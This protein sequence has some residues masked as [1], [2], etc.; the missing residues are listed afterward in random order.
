MGLKLGNTAIGSLYLGST[1][2]SEAYMGSSLIYRA[3]T[4]VVSYPYMIF[5]FASSSA[6]LQ[7]GVYIS[8]RNVSVTQISTSPNRWK[9]EVYHW[10]EID[11]QPQLGRGIPLLFCANGSS[12]TGT[13]TSECTLVEAG[14]FDAMLDGYYCESMDRAFTGCTGLTSLGDVIEVPNVQNVAGMFQNC[15]NVASGQL[16]QY[17][18]FNTY[19][20]SVSNHSGTFSNCGSGTQ[21]GTDELDQIPVGWGGNMIPTSTL[22]TSTVGP[23][24]SSNKTSWVITGNAPDWT[25]I[26]GLYLF[27]QSS[28][29][30]FA[31][32]SMNRSRIATRNGLGTSSSNALYF[33]PSFVQ[34][35]GSSTSN[36]VITWLATTDTP[37][38]SLAVSQGNTDMPGTL[39]YST[40]GPITRTY[41]TYDSSL[42][43]YFQFLVTNVPIANWSGLTDAYGVLYNAGFLTDGGFR[44]FF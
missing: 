40:Y 26:I 20:T 9:L 18:W 15:T 33:Y 6:R 42:G 24:F 8:G 27:T 5:E 21:T 34:C 23:L 29:S 43:V 28:V 25:N 3:T 22:M 13:I 7:P 16:A 32:V 35:T 31:G 44:Y 12:Y 4:P 17:N 39:D 11:N 30:Q 41:G 1:K 19:G 10:F 37:N 14:N 38:G 36:R 2:I